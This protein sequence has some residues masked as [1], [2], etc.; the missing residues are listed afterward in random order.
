M[1]TRSCLFPLVLIAAVA[2]DASAAEF[3]DASGPTAEYQV[4]QGADLGRR[5]KEELRL[6]S[7][8]ARKFS[9]TEKERGARLKPLRE[10]LRGAM[11]KVQAQLSAN[12]PENEV[13]DTLQ[14]ILEARKAIAEHGRRSDAEQAAFLSPSQRARLLVWRSLGGLDGYAARR[15]Q[16]ALAVEHHDPGFEE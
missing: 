15:L 3:A 4:E 13:Q 14:Q 2:A 1:K 5:W 10:K 9:N 7:G 11:V 16:G 12:A 8:Q 6:S